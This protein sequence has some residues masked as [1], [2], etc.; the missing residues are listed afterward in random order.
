MNSQCKSHPKTIK[1]PTN[2]ETNNKGDG[3]N[4]TINIKNYPT[5]AECKNQTSSQ[6]LVSP[7]P[8]KLDVDT[9]TD[10][11]T[12]IATLIV[13]IGSVLTTLLVGW[14]SYVNQRSQIRGS[15]ASFRQQWVS[16]LRLTSAE[17]LASVAQLH[18][19]IDADTSFLLKPESNEKYSKLIMLQSKIE[20]MLD[21]KHANS[22]K[23]ESLLE[24]II[25]NVKNNEKPELNSSVNEFHSLMRDTLENAWQQIK[26]DL[27]GKKLR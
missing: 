19:D 8:L 18:L 27:S 9:P 1:R 24:R 20:L 21:K 3:I 23:L 16:E 5:A 22:T 14:L 15:I 12:V 25:R 13:G 7:Q 17:F 6:I 4:N 2:P 11:P 26:L 10:W